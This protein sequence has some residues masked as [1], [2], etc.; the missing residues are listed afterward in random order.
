MS[1]GYIEFDGQRYK[2]DHLENFKFEAVQSAI[3]TKSEIRTEIEVMFS[4]HCYTRAPEKN[5]TVYIHQHKGEQ[6]CFCPVRYK[7]SK[8][9]P[10]IIKKLSERKVLQT[11]KGNFLTIEIVDDNGKKRDYE[12]YFSLRKQGK[13]QPL[14][15]YVESAYL[16]DYNT[17]VSKQKKKQQPIRFYILVYK[18][19]NEL[20]IPY[21]K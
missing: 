19:K 17:K 2:L 6:R 12:I 13:K 11:G 15:L 1:W 9:L 7:Y 8:I 10:S 20:R 18:V 14:K 4:W 5:E 16:R 3:E 21:T